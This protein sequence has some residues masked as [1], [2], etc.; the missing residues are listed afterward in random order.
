MQVPVGAWRDDLF[1]IFQHGYCHAS[2]VWSCCCVPI[3][4]AQ[5]ATRLHLTWLGTSG[6]VSEST[7]TFR[8]LWYLMWT[9]CAI[10]ATMLYLI[11]LGTCGFRHY[12]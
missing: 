5:V 1:D 12:R 2:A 7:V 8:K 9:Y 3:A 6:T 11:Y 4:V 10:R